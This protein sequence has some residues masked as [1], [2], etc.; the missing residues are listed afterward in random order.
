MRQAVPALVIAGTMVLVVAGLFLFRPTGGSGGAA[1]AAVEQGATG[2]VIIISPHN[3]AI[4]QEFKAAFE[5]WHRRQFGAA[6]EVLWQDHGGT[7]DAVRYIR[8][9]FV[10]SPNGIGADIF[11]GGGIEPYI[12]LAGLG[13]LDVIRLPEAMKAAIPARIGGVP[14]YDAQYR[15]YG[16]ALSGFGI[17]YNKKR[18]A[19]K[20]LPEPKTWV[21]LTRPEFVGEVGAA[22][23][24]DSGT[25]SAMVE[26]ILQALGW[27]K[28]FEALTRIGGN[29]RKFSRSAGEIPKLVS[30]GDE[31]AGLAIDFY[32][33][34]QIRRDGK[35]KIGF[36]LPAGLTPL[37]PDGIGILKGAANREAA[38]RF[39]EFVLSPEG[40]ELWVL[41]VRN[42]PQA[43]GP[44]KTELL[45]IP[46]LP[47]V[48]KMHKAVTSVLFDPSE[49]HIDFV[50]DADKAA[51]R[52]EALKDLYGA[53]FIDLAPEL[54]NAWKAV[55]ARGLKP[56]EVRTLCTPPVTEQE[57]TELSRSDW[58]KP[59]IRNK[60]LTEWTTQARER[61]QKLA[62]GER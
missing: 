32:A 20:H 9:A 56:D 17:I 39:V 26:V 35:E 4:Q 6:C 34:T 49:A 58:S 5:A 57:L 13:D 55:I 60:R 50:Y 23:P 52:R 48:Y 19:D 45:R 37:T 44:A 16:T 15:W 62:R 21:D 61:Y 7:S 12:L 27:E 2:R 24:R 18:L 53:L 38:R 25:A 47:D 40:Q 33:W 29:V 43:K 11:W 31:S 54:S 51:T 10:G 28:G 59:N 22:D 30:L 41:P 36:V 14:L 46:V 3:E 42:T 8:D 1:P